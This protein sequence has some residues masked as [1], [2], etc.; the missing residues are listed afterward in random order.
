[1]SQTWGGGPEGGTLTWAVPTFP[2]PAGVSLVHTPD[3]GEAKAESQSH[4]NQSSRPVRVPQR[5]G[6]N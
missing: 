4:T 6:G 5:S 2:V 3:Q 1:M